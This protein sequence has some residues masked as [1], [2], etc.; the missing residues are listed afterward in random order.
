M[1]EEL[2]S[3]VGKERTL[4]RKPFVRPSLSERLE[5]TP[6]HY[7][8]LFT[9]IYLFAE[10]CGNR[11]RQFWIDEIFTYDLANLP[12]IRQIWPLIRQ[13]IEL[14]PPLPFWI[15]W[16]VHHTLG[17]GEFVSRLPSI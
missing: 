1:I 3:D 12:S 11:R 7:L 4:V 10:Y 14:N 16:V 9:A 8:L 17:R 6:G 15:T 5:A 2:T 13:G